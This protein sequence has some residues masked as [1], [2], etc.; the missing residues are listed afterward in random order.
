[1]VSRRLSTYF[2]PF[3]LLLHT[4]FKIRKYYFFLIIFFLFAFVFKVHFTG[5]K[6]VLL[7]KNFY[8]KRFDGRCN[9]LQFTKRHLSPLIS[10]LIYSKFIESNFA[11]SI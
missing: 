6:S 10:F 7:F 11:T 1:M 9:Y 8:T 2:G 4:G 5:I 3:I